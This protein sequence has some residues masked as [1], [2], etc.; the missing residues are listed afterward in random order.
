MREG[1]LRRTLTSYEAS[2]S[3]EVFVWFQA[4][5]GDLPPPQEKAPFGE[6]GAFYPKSESQV[7]ES[8]SFP[9]RA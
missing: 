4:V 6:S 8:S 3:G 1:T 5:G 9:I 7:L 2:A